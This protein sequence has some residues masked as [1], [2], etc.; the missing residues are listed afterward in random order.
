[1]AELA[2][3]QVD[4]D[5]PHDGRS[6]VDRDGGNRRLFQPGFGRLRKWLRPSR[7]LFR[8]HKAMINPRSGIAVAAHERILIKF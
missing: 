7:I 6:L 3:D 4:D 1:M 5:V 8:G 2:V